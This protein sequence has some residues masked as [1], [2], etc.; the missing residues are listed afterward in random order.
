MEFD[1]EVF[2]VVATFLSAIIAL[3]DIIFWKRHRH[4][5]MPKVIEYAYSFFPVLLIVLLLRSFIVERFRIPTGSLEPTLLPGD[6]IATNK[7]DYGLRLPVIHTKIMKIGEPVTGDIVVFRLPSNPDEDLIK[8]TIGTPGDK[9]RYVNKVLYI[10]NIKQPL[11]DLGPATDYDEAGNAFTVEK[12]REI[13][14]GVPHL[15]YLNP[16][17]PAQDFSITVPPDEYFMMGDNRD[18]SADSR[19][20]GFLPEENI[21]GRAFFIW[22]SWDSQTNSVRWHR[23]GSLISHL[24]T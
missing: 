16:N 24:A 23:M 15:I 4:A 17:V 13:L 7:F 20:W 11:I 5:E 3:L 10:N 8:R 14:N 6:W 21:I 1:F 22:F 12:Y 9:I 2:L 19:Y 18:N